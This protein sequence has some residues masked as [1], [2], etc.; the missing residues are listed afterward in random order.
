MPELALNLAKRALQ[1]VARDRVERS[2]RLLRATAPWAKRLAL[3]PRRRAVVVL[4]TARAACA[5][6]TSASSST[7]ASSLATR[8]A[9]RWVLQPRSDRVIPITRDAR[10]AVATSRAT[11]QPVALPRGR[12]ARR[13]LA[14]APPWGIPDWRRFGRLHSR[15]SQIGVDFNDLASIGVGVPRFGP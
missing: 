13:F 10:A 15:P 7:K 2:K 12:D 1:A 5:A 9:M 14:P 4:R 11:D 8:S 3:E 6:R